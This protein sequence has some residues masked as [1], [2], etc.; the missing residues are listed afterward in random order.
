MY[1]KDTITPNMH[2]HCHLMDI[3]LYHGPVASFW[4]FSFERCNGILGSTP[5]NKRSVELQLMRQ[6]LLSHF[7][8]DGKMPIMFKEDFLML[9][10]EEKEGKS[11]HW[12][13]HSVW[14]DRWAVHKLAVNSPMPQGH[15]WSNHSAVF[16]P[17]N[18]KLC[19]LDVDDAN[20][21]LKVYQVMYPTIVFSLK[22]MGMLIQKFGS[23]V[24]GTTQFGSRIEPRQIRSSMV[25]ASWPA[26]VGEVNMTSFSLTPGM[27]SYYFPH[28]LTKQDKSVVH[29]FACVKW[30][31]RDEDC[32]LIGKPVQLWS[33]D[34]QEGGPSSFIPVQRIYSQFAYVKVA[35]SSSI[36]VSPILRKTFL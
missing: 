17:T 3:V 4:C 14:S 23:V 29:T 21:L 26:N 8:E 20:L 24:N 30:H 12:L 28:S 22:D 13:E 34:Y 33:S 7:F 18:Y 16:C 1:G 2:L 11:S 6:F 19:A 36:A 5:T 31:K 9:C 15:V 25:L 10:S 32:D 35:N 27:V